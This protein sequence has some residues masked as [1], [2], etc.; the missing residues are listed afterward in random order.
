MAG[1]AMM[2][3][4]IALISVIDEAT[5]RFRDGEGIEGFCD[6][7]M[8]GRGPLVVRNALADSRFANNPL[9]IGEPGLRFYC[10]API[11]VEGRVVGIFCVTDSVPLQPSERKIEGIVAL[12][13]QAAE[14]IRMRGEVEAMRTARGRLA[15]VLDALQVGVL[16][17]GREG[18]VIQANPAASA[19][20][21][22]DLESLSMHSN[23]EGYQILHFGGEPMALPDRPGVRALR[24]ETVWDADTRLRWADGHERR[25]R[26]NARPLYLDLDTVPYS[27]V[28]TLIDVTLEAGYRTQFDSLLFE[29]AEM[30]DILNVQRSQLVKANEQLACL[31]TTDGLTGL[32]NHRAFQ[33]RLEQEILRATKTGVPLSIALV[34]VDH[35]KAFNDEFGHQTGDAV[36]RGVAQS[37]EGGVRPSDLAARYGG[38]EFVIIMPATDPGAAMMA[39]E[40][41]RKAIQSLE[42]SHRS[43]T[44]SFGV[45][46]FGPGMDRQGLLET[47]D[48]ALYESKRAGRNRVT[49]AKGTDSSVVIQTA[50]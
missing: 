38:E 34:D 47:A 17:L 14:T 50:A 42:W 22:G 48:Q 45:A 23:P 25:V 28:C 39:C 26:W 35:F 49:L 9:V 16:M 15:S 8:M 11:V 36:L 41:L 1:A 20:L 13:R 33:E 5:N 4:P 46:A 19:V 7:A 6:L 31:A 30:N 44:A 29:A 43:V 2:D 32:R 18:Q 37:L 12:A 3:V 21:E 40:R 27:T 10:G 24:G